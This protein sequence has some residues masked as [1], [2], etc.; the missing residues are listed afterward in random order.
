MQLHKRG[1]N[2]ELSRDVINQVIVEVD[3]L[4]FEAVEDAIREH[5]Y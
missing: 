3:L 1:G 2:A 4:Q 5:F